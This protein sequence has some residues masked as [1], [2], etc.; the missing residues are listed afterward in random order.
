MPRRQGE[1]NVYECIS[2]PDRVRALGSRT[3]SGGIYACG[4]VT[5]GRGYAC[6]MRNLITTWRR[7]WSAV[8]ST[9]DPLFPFGLV[10]LAAGTSE[11][12][13]L[14]M[15][16]FRH[17]Q[18]AGYG[19]LPGPAG[20]GMEN[21]FVA[22]AYDAGDP[23]YRAG[24][25]HGAGVNSQVDSPFQEAYDLPFPGRVGYSG[26][27]HQLFTPQYM[28][29]L[30]PRAKQTIGRRL[31]LAGRRVAYKDETVP[32]TGPV[33]KNCSV[34]AE[35]ALCPPGAGA[36]SRLH[37]DINQR[38]I[39]L[40]FDEELLGQDAV[41]LWPTTPDTEGLTMLAMYNCING[42][43]ISSC[44][45]NVSCVDRCAR[46]QTDTCR[47][48]WAATPVG[49]ASNGLNPAQYN[50][51]HERAR[52]GR[53]VSPLEVQLNG[54]LWMPAAISFNA[55]H[56]QEPPVNTGCPPQ[57]A[58]PGG[59]PCVNGSRKDGWSSVVAM[60]PV[61]IPVG[62][63]DGWDGT[64]WRQCPPPDRLRPGQVC[65]NCT[66]H[67]SITG[68]RYAWSDSPCCGGNLATGIVPCPVNSC[69][70]STWNSTLPAVPFMAQVEMDNNT[71]AAEGRCKCFAPQTC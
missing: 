6:S 43:C 14:N 33:L 60:A 9:T 45:A 62:C 57:P 25:M 37:G 67:F 63:G 24:A 66:A 19:F 3:A 29:G 41:R 42:S 34:H 56:A 8:P 55:L 61:S 35:N 64:A 26:G 65:T 52:T 17:A 50:S 22:Q 12:H 51:G 21:T 54:T 11:G 40:R 4:D 47:N 15:P 70:I 23:G 18:T 48:G 71:A 68:V 10:S 16:N 28:G 39:T 58:H 38:Q 30:H 31:A 36:C 1:N 20:S 13:E 49:P 5:K 69:P 59:A 53:S 27:G 46:L 32:F 2:P 7:L 44:G